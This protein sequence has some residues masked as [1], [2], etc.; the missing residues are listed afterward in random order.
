MILEYDADRFAAA[1]MKL[2]VRQIGTFLR[3][4][5]DDPDVE[6][7]KVASVDSVERTEIIERYGRGDPLQSRDGTVLEWIE[8]QAI[9]KGGALAVECGGR[10]VSY[11]ELE[12]VA[13]D[14]AEQLPLYGTGF[15]SVVGLSISRSVEAIAGILGIL[16]SGAAYL[17]LDPTYPVERLEF[18]VRD[19]CAS[20]IVTD[21]KTRGAWVGFNGQ[22]VEWE[23]RVGAAGARLVEG[24]R[25]SPRGGDLAYV[26]YTSGSTGQPKGVLIEHQN[27]ANST[28]ARLQYYS[29]PVQRYLMVS[30]IAFD[31][32]VAGIFWT[33]AQGGTLILPEDKEVRDPRRLA[34]LI[35]GRRVTHLLCLPSLYRFILQFARPDELRT[36][37]CAIVAGEPCPASLIEEHRRCCPGARLYNEYGPTEATVWSTV[38]DTSEQAP[39]VPVPIGRPIPGAEIYLLDPAGSLAPPGWPG[40]ICIGGTGVARGYLNRPELTAACFTVVPALGNIRVYRTGDLGRFRSDGQIEFL[41]RLDQQVK[42]RGYRV[43][44]SEIEEVLKAHPAVQEAAVV[45]EPAGGSV[46]QSANGQ[47]SVDQL[48]LAMAGLDPETAERLLTE[49]EREDGAG[50]GVEPALQTPDRRIIRTQ[51]FD[52]TFQIKDPA[53]IRPPRESQRDWLLSRAAHEFAEDLN[54]LNEVA[55]RFVPG[56]PPDV[57][58]LKRDRSQAKLRED[59]ILEDWHF[60]LML[61]MARCVTEGKGDVLEIGFGRGISAGMIQEFGVRS[62]TI[63]ECNDYVVREYFNPWRARYPDRDI[64]L[65]QAKWQEAIDDLGMYD[66]VFCQTYP[67]NEQEMVEGLLRTS[68]FAEPFFPVAA[69]HLREGG[70]FTYL[71]HEIDSL[72]RRHQ[73]LLFQYFRSVSLSVQPL[74]IDPETKDLWWADSMVVVKAIK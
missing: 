56:T 8:G 36:L 63:V 54:H 46:S 44:L 33:L 70:V 23:K 73:R 71:T 12:R 41:G 13:A 29:E 67:L 3:S 42:I 51:R 22:V 6:I 2:P 38:F 9:E 7:G 32:S 37:R 47:I 64:R 68:T 45:V 53:F 20:V 72:S 62:H 69:A 21:R 15:G 28:R 58:A 4:A 31:S 60:S 1:E 48:V 5:M 66:G 19:A 24:K 49:A 10:S 18:M 61:A 74:E 55:E 27:L 59:E 25:R 16:K 17:P 34:E 14:L 39:G 40:E 26:M 65:V 43:E 52:L 30:S 57:L 35:A 50:L 11:A